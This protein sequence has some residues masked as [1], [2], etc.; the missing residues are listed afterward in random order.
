MLDGAGLD[1]GLDAVFDHD[2]CELF[3]ANLQ[4]FVVAHILIVKDHAEAF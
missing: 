2:V 1:D 4:A 3:L